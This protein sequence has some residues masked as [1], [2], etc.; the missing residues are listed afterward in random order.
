VQINNAKLFSNI[1]VEKNSKLKIRQY[2]SATM[3]AMK[4]LNCNKP[5]NLRIKIIF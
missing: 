3:C 2:K 5:I 4:C 1:E